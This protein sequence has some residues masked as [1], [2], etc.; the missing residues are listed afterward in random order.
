M[1]I[2]SFLCCALFLFCLSVC[3][4]LVVLLV[5]TLIAIHL[6]QSVLLVPRLIPWPLRN[7]VVLL[8]VVIKRSSIHSSSL[9]MKRQH[10]SRYP[11]QGVR[12][13]E[14]SA[15]KVRPP[16]V[17]LPQF[18]VG[19]MVHPPQRRHALTLTQTRQQAADSRHSATV[20]VLVR[21]LVRTLV[22][23]LDRLIVVALVKSSVM[24]VR[25]VDSTALAE[26]RA[27]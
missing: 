16:T 9:R 7:L 21:I 3:A 22:P 26:H 19:M 12:V 23:V 14:Q 1:I 20:H 27:V 2:L 5:S 15:F 10:P 17:N 18:V 4:R 6:E 8:L 13:E 11:R 24:I 25:S